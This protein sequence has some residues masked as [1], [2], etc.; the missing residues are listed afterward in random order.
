MLTLTIL[1]I[2]D[3]V[4]TAADLADIGPG[5]MSGNERPLWW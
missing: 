5:D 2:L 3:L 1:T 4:S